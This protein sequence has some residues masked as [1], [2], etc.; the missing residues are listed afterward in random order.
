MQERPIAN[1]Y[2]VVFNDILT[3]ENQYLEAQ[4]KK[5]NLGSFSAL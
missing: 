4:K 5:K 3:V 1:T 2:A